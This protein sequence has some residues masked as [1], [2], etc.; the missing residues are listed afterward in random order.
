MIQTTENRSDE[1]I[2]QMVLDGQKEMYGVLM[3]RYQNLVKGY[4][5]HLCRNI[6]EAA[7]LSQETFITGYQCLGRLKQAKAFPGW[8]L[9]ILKNKY[10]NLGRENK[11]P[12][13]PLGELGMDLPDSVQ[14]SVYSEEQLKK[15]SNYVYSLPENYREVILMRYLQDFSYKEIARI[16][17]IPVTTVTKRLLYARAFLLKKAKED[18]LI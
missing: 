9:G 16:L 1:E 14:N 7:D 4:A 3:E 11:I 12:T 2:I 10:R 17:E 8:I 13:I 6:E 5:Y 15:I 18:G